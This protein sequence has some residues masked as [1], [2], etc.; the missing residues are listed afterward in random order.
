MNPERILMSKGGERLEEVIG[1]GEDEEL[2]NFGDGAFEIE[3]GDRLRIGKK[4]VDS[5]FL[6]KYMQEGAVQ[7]HAMRSFIDSIQLVDPTEFICSKVSRC[8][9]LGLRVFVW[10]F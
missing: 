10:L 4:M 7:R 8:R 9:F 2:P 1:R 6:D 3:S 5:G